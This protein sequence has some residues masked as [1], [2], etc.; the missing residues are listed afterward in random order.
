M[1]EGEC[2][3]IC[4]DAVDS[5]ACKL[6]CGHVFHSSC[7]LQS[8]LHD[9]RCPVCRVEIAK[10][11]PTSPP[12]VV[13]V[14]LTMNDVDSAMD[15]EY[16][17]MRRRQHNYAARR[18]RFL[19]RRPE[20]HREDEEMRRCQRELRDVERSIAAQ[21]T[22]EANALWMGPSFAS[23]KKERGLLLRRIRRRE[24]T[25]DEAVTAELGE[26][27]DM[28]EEEEESQVFRAIAR[29]SR[30]RTLDQISDEGTEGEV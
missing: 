16:H 14:E 21:W 19:R 30:R 26:R 13:N 9:P 24:R 1:D 23:V 22:R 5:Q 18:R 27:P 20:L 6:S 15:D 4:L 7:V 10:R 25:V 11:P 3:A 2:C 28:D 17:S 8:A 12:R 29:L